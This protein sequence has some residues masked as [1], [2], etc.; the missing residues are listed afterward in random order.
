MKMGRYI[1]IRVFLTFSSLNQLKIIF[2]FL[3]GCSSYF[4]MHSYVVTNTWAPEI[5]WKSIGI[6]WRILM[7][8]RKL[9]IWRSGYFFTCKSVQIPDLWHLNTNTVLPGELWDNI[10]STTE[11]PAL[12]C[13]RNKHRIDAVR[14]FSF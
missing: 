5:Q 2:I 6:N 13:S 14:K 12:S 8:M 10:C 3:E 4:Y 9:Q 1:S 11:L 7:S